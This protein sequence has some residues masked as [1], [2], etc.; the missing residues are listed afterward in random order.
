ME[1]I[2]ISRTWDE[3]ERNSRALQPDVPISRPELPGSQLRHSGSETK[4]GI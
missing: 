2:L 1:S 3:G 4:I